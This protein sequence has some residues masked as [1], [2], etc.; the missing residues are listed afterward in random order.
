M[1][2]IPYCSYEPKSHKNW[3]KIQCEWKNV[4]DILA[5]LFT[6]LIIPPR[7]DN[8]DWQWVFAALAYIFQG[9]RIFKYAII[10][11]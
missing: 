8:S 2:F 9:L 3:R 7:T 6:L 10:V 11:E 5:I 4:L 1:W